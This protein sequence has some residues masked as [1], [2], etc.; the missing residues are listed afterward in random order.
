[1]HRCSGTSAKEL[2]SF[3]KEKELD[4]I[5]KQYA[6]KR[7]KNSYKSDLYYSL[8]FNDIFFCTVFRK[9]K[10][11]ALSHYFQQKKVKDMIAKH[12]PLIDMWFQFLENKDT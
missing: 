1:M 11:D 7:L 5:V 8:F 2:H 6:K 3:T 12:K 9:R 4:H 10:E